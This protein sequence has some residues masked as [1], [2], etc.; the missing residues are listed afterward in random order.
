MMTIP[1]PSQKSDDL[2][3]KVTSMVLAV[4]W[5]K[6]TSVGEPWYRPVEF[7]R[8][9]LLQCVVVYL[10]TCPV[11]VWSAVRVGKGRL[12]VSKK[13]EWGRVEGWNGSRKNYHHRHN[14]RHRQVSHHENHPQSPPLLLIVSASSSSSRWATGFVWGEVER[15]EE[16]KAGKR[17][18]ECSL[19]QP[20]ANQCNTKQPSANRYNTRQPT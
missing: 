11:L 16:V 9:I 19:L 14:H 3:R 15:L 20:S 6:L 18:W 1:W 5:D 17:G 8:V 2:L 7:Y 12:W 4:H 10:C 13:I